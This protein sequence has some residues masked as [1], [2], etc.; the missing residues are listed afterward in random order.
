MDNDEVDTD[1]ENEEENSEEAPKANDTKTAPPKSE[2]RWR[3]CG[4]SC[5]Q[6]TVEPVAAL[7][8]MTSAIAGPQIHALTYE[9]V[10]R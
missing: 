2:K 5:Y 7:F 10:C 1:Y 4:F 8:I 3:F 9:K 6:M